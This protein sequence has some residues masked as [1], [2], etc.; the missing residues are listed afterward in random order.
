MK[1]I[2][3]KAA[4]QPTKESIEANRRLDEL[5]ALRINTETVL[6]PVRA[7][8][9]IDGIPV[10]EQEDLA[11]IKAKQKAGKTTALKIIVSAWLKGTMF[12]LKSELNEP[13]IL[14]L[15][16]E[17]KVSDVKQII[18]DIQQMTELDNQYIDSH[19]KLYTVRKLSYKTLENDLTLLIKTYR[20][21]VVIIDGIVDF[22]ESFNDETMSHSL[23]N[24][25]LVLGDTYHCIIICVLHENKRAEDQNMRG[26]LGTLLA[27]KASTVLQCKKTENGC[28]AV[29]CSDSRHQEMPEWKIKYD[30]HGHIVSADA[31]PP[32]PAAM[33]RQAISN[34]LLENGGSLSRKDLTAKLEVALNR[35]RPTI[36]NLISQELQNGFLIKLDDLELIQVNPQIPIGS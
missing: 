19:L 22:I 33:R 32:S 23:V 18:D 1:K 21:D 26:H 27:Q 15:D 25:I 24:N 10:F 36:S 34:V 12:R 11:A 20:P 6:S 5:N 16:T 30:E 4:K 14:W 9:S 3:K 13:K 7:A 35:R 17:Q 28:I 29:T 8:L 31:T 2:K